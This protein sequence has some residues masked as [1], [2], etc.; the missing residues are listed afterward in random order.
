MSVHVQCTRHENGVVCP[1]KKRY[2]VVGEWQ[3]REGSSIGPVLSS[4]QV[5]AGREQWRWGPVVANKQVGCVC[6]WEGACRW[7][8]CESRQAVIQ[9]R[10]GV[11]YMGHE[12]KNQRPPEREGRRKACMG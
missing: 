12:G 10:V 3:G 1:G 11:W 8:A 9:A 2:K 6:V 7:W 5:V 4:R